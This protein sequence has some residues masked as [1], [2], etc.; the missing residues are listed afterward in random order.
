M[1]SQATILSVG[2]KIVCFSR[3]E[4]VVKKINYAK[5]KRGAYALS[6]LAAVWGF[7]RGFQ[8]QESKRPLYINLTSLRGTAH[9]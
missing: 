1:G 6:V 2:G 5:A 8:P 7:Y 4:G 9:S 3:G